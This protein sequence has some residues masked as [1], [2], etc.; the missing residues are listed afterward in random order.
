MEELT[1]LHEDHLDRLQH[2]YTD[3]LT[4]QKYDG[5][6]LYSGHPTFHFA[7]DQPRSFK[8]YAHF[9]H[10]VPL[11]GIAYSLLASTDQTA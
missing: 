1:P 6:L 3:L 11:P 10:W 2:V 4:E 5:V 9:L 8:S 7:D